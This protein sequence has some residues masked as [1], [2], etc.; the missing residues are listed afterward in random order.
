MNKELTIKRVTFD[1]DKLLTEMENI[2]S[3]NSDFQD[4]TFTPGQETP[5][6]RY[7]QCLME[8][9]KCYKALHESQCSRERSCID[10][11]EIQYKMDKLLNMVVKTPEDDFQIRRYNI[12]LIEKE[13]NLKTAIELINDAVRR[14]NKWYARK[15]KLPVFTRKEFEAAERES[16]T[17]RLVLDSQDELLGLPGVSKGNTQALRQMQIGLSKN[18]KGE[19]LVHDFKPQE[20]LENKKAGDK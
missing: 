9:N 18:N 20:M 2:P 8:L 19:L 6:R 14:A 3:G 5:T 1:F 17:K 16:Y 7:R 13:F 4:D 10:I 15:L 11:E 12:D